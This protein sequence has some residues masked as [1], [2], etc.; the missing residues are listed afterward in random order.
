MMSCG[1]FGAQDL[2]VS[3]DMEFLA[4]TMV[5]DVGASGSVE[6]RWRELRRR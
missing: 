6:R 3:M 2:M 1:G 5:A 4:S